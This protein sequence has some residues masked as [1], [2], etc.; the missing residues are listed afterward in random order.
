MHLAA[1]SWASALTPWLVVWLRKFRPVVDDCGIVW[2]EMCPRLL[3]ENQGTVGVEA[4]TICSFVSCARSRL[5]T[6]HALVTFFPRPT[7]PDRLSSCF[8]FTLH[9]CRLDT[10]LTLVGFRPD[11]LPYHVSNSHLRPSLHYFAYDRFFCALG[12]CKI[13]HFQLAVSRILAGDGC[14]LAKFEVHD[15]DKLLHLVEPSD[16]CTSCSLHPMFAAHEAAGKP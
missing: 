3:D 2:L 5:V 1:L 16:H 9:L 12:G 4:R 7:R 6:V 11:I 14:K 10:V 8:F 13:W 15:C